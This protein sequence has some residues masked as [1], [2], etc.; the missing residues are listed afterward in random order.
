M[1]TNK[2]KK[3]LVIDETLASFRESSGIIISDYQ[4][5]TVE[6]ISKLRRDLRKVGAKYK[7]VK[8]TLSKKVL[9][10]LSI[11]S[12]DAYFTGVTG[13]IF[14]KEYVSAIKVLTKF[15]KENEAF[16]IKGGYLDN[17][18]FNVKEITEISKL[19]SKEE[20]IGK[21]VYLLNQPLTRLMNVLSSP[22]REIVTVLSAIKDKK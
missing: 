22:S 18:A 9:K 8:N 12:L 5:L 19:S 2:E 17:K 4:G 16:K 10:E 20:L 21:L 6:K 1:A 3:Q 15:A 14:C 13:I 11:T 7:V